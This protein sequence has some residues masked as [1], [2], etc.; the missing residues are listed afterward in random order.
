MEVERV[1]EGVGEVEGEREVEGHWVGEGVGEPPSEE[2]GEEDREEVYVEET[3]ALLAREGEGAG[4][5]VGV[6]ERDMVKVTAL[7]V[8]VRESVMEKVGEMVAVGVEVWEAEG[9]R[10]EVREGEGVKLEVRVALEHW[11]F[12][13]VRDRE[14]VTVVEGVW[15]GLPPGGPV[16]DR[17]RVGECVEVRERVG[18][19]Q[20]EALWESVAQ[21]VG[22]VEGVGRGE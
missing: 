1:R 11:E 19:A 4:V 18:V 2:V 15:E 6:T 9:Q 5:M 8:M 22:D 3:L 13:R 14:S 12:E 17:Q 10:E 16:A 20:G 21:G 7:G